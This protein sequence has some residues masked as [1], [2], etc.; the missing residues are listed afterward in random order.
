MG[1][2]WQEL[3]F[4]GCLNP[5]FCVSDAFEG[6][7]DLLFAQ[8]TETELPR[9]CSSQ[10]AREGYH[11]YW[12][13]FDIFVR[14]ATGRY[15]QSGL[16]YL[17]Y[18]LGPFLYKLRDTM[19]SD[20]PG[21]RI[22]RDRPRINSK[23]MPIEYLQGFPEG[24][25]GRYMADYLVQNRMSLGELEIFRLLQCSSVGEEMPRTK[26]PCRGTITLPLG[27]ATLGGQRRRRGR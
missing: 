23:T 12:L 19:L 22:L 3:G 17:D 5:L 20:E 8:Q 21:R 14:P 1:P 7:Q 13:R 11:L 27:S 9:P 24:T 18:Y 2:V 4:A 25:L 16:L 15:V 10:Q 6:L 26:P